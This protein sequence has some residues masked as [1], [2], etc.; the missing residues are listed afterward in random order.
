MSFRGH[1]VKD[2]S[3]YK[4]PRTID[5]FYVDRSHPGDSLVFKFCMVI[6]CVFAVLII[7]GVV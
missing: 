5:G 4:T 3:H 2:W 6:A 1:D 7:W